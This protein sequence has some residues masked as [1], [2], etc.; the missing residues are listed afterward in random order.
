MR[1][2]DI[3]LNLLHIAYAMSNDSCPRVGEAK[4]LITAFSIFP[5]VAFISNILTIVMI[6]RTAAYKAFRHRL[7]LYLAIAGVICT[8]GYWL[9][10]LPVD[11]E[12]PDDNPVSVR[13]GWSDAC[14]FSGFF[15]Q[16]AGWIR[17]LILF[18]ICLHIFAVVIYQNQLSRPKQEVFGGLVVLLVPL[19]VSWEPFIKDSYGLTGVSCWIKYSCQD[20][21]NNSMDHLII[22]LCVSVVPTFLLQL[23]DVA[24]ILAAIFALCRSSRRGLLKHKH[25]LAIKEILPLIMFPLLYIIIGF[26]RI[27]VY[28]AATKDEIHYALSDAV[29]VCLLQ[30]ITVTI[31]LS[32]ILQPGFCHQCTTRRKQP[33][34]PLVPSKTSPSDPHRE[35][36]NAD[37]C[38]EFGLNENEPDESILL[39]KEAHT[40]STMLRTATHS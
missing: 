34:N 17:S 16:Y 19:L 38:S 29:F 28:L 30:I 24:L 12:Q 15:N 23:F 40:Y 2:G 3:S 22:A 11:I 35:E 14:K 5:A 4:W 31:P 32:L 10:V 26:V 39:S 25:W 36:N 21:T 13:E 8:I 18:W 37:Y 9:E 7:M 6:V 27:T 1:W 20:D 33:G